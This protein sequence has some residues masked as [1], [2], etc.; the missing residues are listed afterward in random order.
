L[1]SIREK[2]VGNSMVANWLTASQSKILFELLPSQFQSDSL[3]R[4]KI[5]YHSRVDRKMNRRSD[6]CH[7]HSSGSARSVALSFQYVHLKCEAGDAAQRLAVSNNLLDHFVRAAN[8]QYSVW[9]SPSIK[10]GARDGWP[11]A[12]LSDV[13][14]GAGVA[15]KEVVSRLLG[16]RCDMPEGMRTNL[17]SIGQV[18]R[19]FARLTI[20]IDERT[21][22]ARSPHS[23][24]VT[25]QPPCHH[26]RYGYKG[27]GTR[28][29]HEHGGIG[30]R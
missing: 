24:S 9:P 22:A 12:L 23:R 10:T 8:Q 19:T 7:A 26:K 17:Q 30:L 29:R 18:P 20:K 5:E 27:R 15:G 1:V 6:Y 21:K 3:R 2:N 25:P 4:G 16:C 14:E 11:S 28:L 13:S